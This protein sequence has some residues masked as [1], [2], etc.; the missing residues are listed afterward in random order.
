MDVANHDAGV[1]SASALPS[2]RRPTPFWL[3]AAVASAIAGYLLHHSGYFSD[4]RLLSA[5]FAVVLASASGVVLVGFIANRRH[6][7]PLPVILATGGSVVV[8]TPVQEDVEALA[9]IHARYLGRGLFVSLGPAFLRAYYAGFLSSPYGIASIAKVK[10]EPVGMLVGTTDQR[11]HRH[12]VIRHQV[13]RLSILGL[14]ALATRP[15]TTFRF[16]RTRVSR[17]RDGL[18]RAR[19]IET[20]GPTP[21]VLTHVAVLLGARAEGVG[22]K[23]VDDFETKAREGGSETAILTTEGGSSG[24]TD[25]YLG[26]GWGVTGTDFS[27]DGDAITTMKKDLT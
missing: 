26:R 16:L 19:D 24:A 11:Q 17:Y 3:L 20:R 23:L 5:V 13:A 18:K 10:G 6:P 21:A 4:H 9:A 2:R 14:S 15:L 25:F 12:W 7:E 22:G 27:L 8:S 1:A